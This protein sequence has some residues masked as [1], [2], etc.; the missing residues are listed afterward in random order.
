VGYLLLSL[1]R[2]AGW[3]PGQYFNDPGLNDPD[4]DRKE[5]E[6]QDMDECSFIAMPIF[7]ANGLYCLC[8]E[9]D[10]VEHAEHHKKMEGD[11]QP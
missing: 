7:L 2:K 9:M 11:D 5:P 3:Y 10:A 4:A 1:R 8:Q 6:A